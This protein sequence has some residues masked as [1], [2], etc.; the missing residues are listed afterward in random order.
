[1]IKHA[2][3]SMLNKGNKIGTIVMNLSK[4]YD[5]LNH[6]LL[7][8]KLKVYGFNTNAFTFIQSCFSNRHQ[9]TKVGDKFSKWQKISTVVSQGPILGPLFFNSLRPILQSKQKLVALDLVEL[10]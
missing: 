8:F 5:M 4:A 2:W 3:R 6:N 10:F 9:R 1:M 7:L